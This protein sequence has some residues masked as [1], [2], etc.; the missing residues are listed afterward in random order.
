ML[1]WE[2]E[3]RQVAVSDPKIQHKLQEFLR[4]LSKMHQ[5]KAVTELKNSPYDPSCMTGCFLKEL[6]H[7]I[8]IHIPHS[9]HCPDSSLPAGPSA[10]AVL[11]LASHR[12]NVGFHVRVDVTGRS[13][14]TVYGSSVYSDDSCLHTAAVHFGIVRVGESKTV[15]LTTRGP[16]IRLVARL[17]RGNGLIPVLCHRFMGSNRNGVKTF[18]FNAWPGSFSF[19]Q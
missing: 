19:V 7:A 14:G 18:S 10:L 17:L 2:L 1:S 4:G 5:A 9:P 3:L 6:L 13:D 12:R 11:D 8:S 15:M 16:Q